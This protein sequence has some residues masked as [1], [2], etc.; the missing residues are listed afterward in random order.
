ME[1][2]TYCTINKRY[3]LVKQL[4]HGG[5][6]TAWMAVDNVTGKTLVLKEI[7]KAKTSRSDFKR[8]LHYSKSLS[9]HPN[10]ITTHNAAYETK[11]S[12]VSVQDCASGGDLFDAIEP[13]VG[14]SE[15]TV[16]LYLGQI[17]SA[18]AYM[19]SKNLVHRDIK[20][21]NIVLSDEEGLSVQ[22]I[23]FGMTL[24]AGTHHSTVSGTVPYLSPEICNASDEAGFFVDPSSDVWSVGILLFCMLTGS[25]PWQQATLSDPNYYQ[26]ILWQ[27]GVTNKIPDSWSIFSPELFSLF[28][29]MLTIRPQDRC[30]IT[31]VFKYLNCSWF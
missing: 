2:T 4:G 25:F 24:Q 12:Y 21:E 27:C 30:H 29:K 20:P 13:R 17:C 15:F 14:L 6:G 22:L 1:F 3:A 31:E 26:F 18:V 9:K 8:E 7:S 11:T 5:Y 10:I 19:H 23:D 16:K 28:N